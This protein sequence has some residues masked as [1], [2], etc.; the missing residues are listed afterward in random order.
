MARNPNKI[1]CRAHS[2]QTGERCRLWAVPGYPV[3]R[4]HGAGGVAPKPISPRGKTPPGNQN[5]RKHGAYSPRLAPEEQTKYEGMLADFER[6]LGGEGKELPA[7]DR[8]LITQLA[9]RATKLLGAVEGN[10]PGEALR[11]L[12]SMVLELLRELKATRASREPQTLVVA[13]PAQLAAQMMAQIAE[14]KP[15]LLPLAEPTD[16]AIEVK[17]DEIQEEMEK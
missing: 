15:G 13:T 10:A 16:D 11:H 6:E 9:A 2:K 17:L 7:S 8:L 1:Q 14:R 5:A 3:C 12:Q 4:F